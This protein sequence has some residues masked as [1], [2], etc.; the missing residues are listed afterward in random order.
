MSRRDFHGVWLL[1]SFRCGYLCAV[2]SV[3]CPHDNTTND[4]R[5]EGRGKRE[6]AKRQR[7]SLRGRDTCARVRYNLY[8][9]AGANDGGALYLLG[10]G[11]RAGKKGGKTRRKG[12][13]ASFDMD[14]LDT[15]VTSD[16]WG[17]VSRGIPLCLQY[18][19]R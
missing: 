12:G 16:F 7:F 17:R 15:N 4:E 8:L 19:F 5:A 1:S 18:M 13:N 14:I 10:A 3:L 11:A 6:K 2:L 9:F